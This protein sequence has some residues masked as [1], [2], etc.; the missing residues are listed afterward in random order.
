MAKTLVS[1]LFWWIVWA[2]SLSHWWC[3]SESRA[4]VDLFATSLAQELG[5]KL[6]LENCVEFHRRRLK[7]N[8]VYFYSV[9]PGTQHTDFFTRTLVSLR[10]KPLPLEAEACPGMTHPFVNLP[11][12]ENPLRSRLR[13]TLVMCYWGHMLL[14]AQ[15]SKVQRTGFT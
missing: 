10:W 7:V 6:L 1:Q 15:C 5:L 12:K 9:T 13:V 11:S 4:C 2:K 14:L 8:L 3:L